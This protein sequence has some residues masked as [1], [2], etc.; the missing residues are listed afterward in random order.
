L[1]TAVDVLCLA[2]E[3]ESDPDFL[4]DLS[5]MKKTPELGFGTPV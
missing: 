3:F 1:D 2:H 4:H 5:W